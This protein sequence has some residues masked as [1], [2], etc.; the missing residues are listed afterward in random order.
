MQQMSAAVYNKETIIRSALNCKNPSSH[1]PYILIVAP[2]WDRADDLDATD[3]FQLTD[4]LHGKVRLARDQRR[5]QW[6]SR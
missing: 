6:P 2:M 3:L 5:L 4:L 1:G